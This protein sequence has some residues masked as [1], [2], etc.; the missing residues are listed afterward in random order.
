LIFF[1]QPAASAE[2]VHSSRFLDRPSDRPN[3]KLSCTLAT[4]R[5]NSLSSKAVRGDQEEASRLSAILPVKLM[6]VPGLSDHNIIKIQAGNGSL[7]AFFQDIFE[8]ATP[9]APAGGS[10]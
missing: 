4:P 6:A 8:L 5:S 1:E 3:L 10:G 7:S 9:S 2:S